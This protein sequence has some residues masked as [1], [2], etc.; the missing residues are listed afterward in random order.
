MQKLTIIGLTGGIGMGKSATAKILSGL[1]LPVHNADLA[2]H[3]LLA[4]GGKAVKPVAKLFPPSFRS[5][6]IDRKKL[7]AIVFDQPQKLKA[8]E[9]IL[10]P[11]VRKTEE[12]FIRQAKRTKA[13]AVVL[14][15]PLLFE[16][17]GEAR[18]DFTICVTAPAAIQRARVL[19]RRDMTPQKFA[20][21]LKRQMPNAERKRRADYV[22]STAVSPADTRR[23]LDAILRQRNLLPDR[24]GKL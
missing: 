16:T 9:R 5:G 19:K 15:I 20:A 7:G 21:I 3:D 13:H 2:V 1:G 11:L 4:A 14:D 8:L 6:K 24:K 22:I 18:C 23:Q 10:H 17:G 12:A